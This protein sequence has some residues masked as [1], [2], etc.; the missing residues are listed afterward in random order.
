MVS[1]TEPKGI[2][3]LVADSLISGTDNA[4]TLATPDHPHGM[5]HVFP[6]GSGFVPKRPARQTCIV[7]SGL[8]IAVVGSVVPMRA[9]REDALAQFR[10]QPDC[11]GASVEL[12]LQQ[13]EADPNGRV[14]LE[15]ID[16][17]L[18]SSRPVGKGWHLHR[19]LSAR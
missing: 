14:V 18:L 2:P 17:L 3:V 12:F 8:A 11:T 4:S 15:N 7:N 5:F 10:N 6:P 19:L 9:F 13:C 1:F 16:V